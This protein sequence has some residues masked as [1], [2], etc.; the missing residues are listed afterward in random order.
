MGFACC[1][2]VVYGE[3]VLGGGLIPKPSEQTRQSFRQCGISVA[4]PRS[5]DTVLLQALRKQHLPTAQSAT[6][7]SISCQ[8]RCSCKTDVTVHRPPRH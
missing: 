7:A 3:R 6:P 2:Q 8:L 1:T 5:A 4:P